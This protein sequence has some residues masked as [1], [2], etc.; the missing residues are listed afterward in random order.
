MKTSILP[1]VFGIVLAGSASAYGTERDHVPALS[2]LSGDYWA[3]VSNGDPFAAVTGTG[4]RA[5]V[6][7]SGP[8]WS[9][10]NGDAGYNW[11]PPNWYR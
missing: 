7:D 6:T 11:A 1:L 10:R 3:L 5:H 2:H 4:A 9:C 8:T